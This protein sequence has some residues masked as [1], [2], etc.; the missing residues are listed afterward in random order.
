MRR[1]LGW[2]G[3]VVLCGVM[4]C[5]EKADPTAPAESPGVPS[6]PVTI[7][8]ADQAKAN[9]SGFGIAAWAVGV[10]QYTVPPEVLGDEVGNELSFYAYRLGNGSVGGRYHYEQTYMGEVFVF[11]GD[12]SCVEI[13]D[14]SRAKIGGPITAS[15]D[16]TIPVGTYGWWQS[17][18]N[19]SVHAGPP[20]QNTLLGFGDEAANQA[21]CDSPNPPRFGPWTVTKG[22]LLVH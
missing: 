7:A 14:E 15:N 5:A 18:D 22:P 3:A 8:E 4:A 17:L 12:V 9:L 1:V 16:A 11:S 6:E 2:V 19:G 13:Y 20:D 21:F 10:I